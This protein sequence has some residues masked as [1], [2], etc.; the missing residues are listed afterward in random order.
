MEHGSGRYVLTHIL[1]LTQISSS[2]SRIE[3][4][5]IGQLIGSES[6]YSKYEPIVTFKK[7][8]TKCQR[9]HQNPLYQVGRVLDSGG[10]CFEIINI[11]SMEYEFVD[12]I[13]TYRAMLIRPWSKEDMNQ[14]VKEYRLSKFK[15]I[16]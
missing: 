5:A 12:L 9:T 10:L 14:A 7:K 6:E 2:S 4:Q 1:K 11:E 13:V 8:Y 16:S 15:V 3:V